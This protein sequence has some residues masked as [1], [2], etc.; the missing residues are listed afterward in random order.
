MFKIRDKILVRFLPI[1]IVPI[2]IV[3]TSFGIYTIK[4]L[5]QNKMGEITQ[6]TKSK[7]DKV[8]ARLCSVE[9]DVISLSTKIVLSD[10]INALDKN[11]TD[12]MNYY[13]SEAENI[14]NIFFEKKEIYCKIQY[15]NEKGLEAMRLQQGDDTFSIFPSGKVEN[16]DKRFLMDTQ[17]LKDGDVSVSTFDLNNEV[18]I[19]AET[20]K[21]V[22]RYTTPVF[23]R[24]GHHR[25]F[26]VLSVLADP[27]FFDILRQKNH[28]DSD[29]YL[30]D[31]EGYYLLHPDKENSLGRKSDLTANANVK[32]DFS[33]EISSRF[34]SGQSGGVS[35]GK[36]F[37]S[38][39]PVFFYPSNSGRSWVLLESLPKSAL[40]SPTWNLFRGLGILVLFTI[41]ASVTAVIVFSRRLTRPLKELITGITTIAETDTDYHIPVTSNDEIAF[42]TFSFNKVLYKLDKSN[43][44]LQDYAGHLEGKIE[45]KTEEIFGKAKQQKVV[46]E[47][48]KF[49]LAN[50]DIQEVMVRVVNRVCNTLRVEFCD[51][52]LLDKS[53]HSFCLACGVGWKEGL[54][55]HATIGLGIKSQA[56]YTLKKETPIVVRDL[57]T[58]TRFSDESHLREHGIVSGLSVPMLVEGRTVGVMGVYTSEERVFLKSDI[59]FLESVGQYMAAAIERKR[60]EDEIVQGKEYTDKLIETAHDAIICIDE[61]GIV[62]V[63]NKAAEK[64]FGYSNNEMIGEQILSIIPEKYKKD[65]QKGLEL[66]SEKHETRIIG[67]TI[68]VSGMKKNGDEIP[69]EMSLSFQKIDNEHHTFTAI[70]RDISL[71]KEA[72]KMLLERSKELRKR[73]KELK[74]FVYIVSHDLKEPLFAIDGYVSRLSGVFGDLLDEKGRRYVDRIK[75]NTEIMSK[76]IHELLEVIK[77][78]MIAYNFD[79]V[80]SK[81]IVD[82]IV[83]ELESLIDNNNIDLSIQ[84]NLPTVMCDAKR[85]KDVFSNL[86]TNAIKFMGEDG[87]RQI[88]VGCDRENGHYKFFI[89]DTGIGIK[90]EY[91][92]Q[93]FKIFRRLKDIDAE[94]TGVGLAIA[95]KI[96]SLHNGKIWVESPVCDGRG[97]KFCFTVPTSKKEKNVSLEP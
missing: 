74:D 59:N 77:V 40:F 81:V 42:L 25:G 95:K 5:K 27:L 53:Q 72:K 64:T 84:D 71:Q 79:D 48:G 54:V 19:D 20:R 63:W 14:F 87:K 4:Y 91:Q 31:R 47:I 3:S 12:R 67:K 68:E 34:L 90:E 60:S 29:T 86:L 69:I 39:T 89:E 65:H 38:F 96:V 75:A 70:I 92:Q 50:I 88:T 11:D 80:N 44:Q 6:R 51:I 73:N 97:S 35:V 36:R 37:Y 9:K 13:R 28:E 93:I 58:E 17:K 76:R 26:F 8:F 30:I 10:L 66:F 24:V 62:K 82:D 22:L 7:T 49:L 15:M 56:G 1:V 32:N 85:L 18:G 43:K 33:R 41:G 78:G 52:L 61:Q 2:F 16:K 46:A 83:L 45:E 21:P 94:G 55:G 57:R 23:D